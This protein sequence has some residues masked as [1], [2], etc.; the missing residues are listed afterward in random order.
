LVAGLD[1]QTSEYV[2]L[3]MRQKME[4]KREADKARVQQQQWRKDDAAEQARKAAAKVCGV[5][6]SLVPVF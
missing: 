1:E 5:W 6:V 2:A 4:V 3:D